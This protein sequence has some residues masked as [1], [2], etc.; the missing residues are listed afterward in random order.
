MPISC[1]PETFYSAQLH[2]FDTFPVTWPQGPA[3]CPALESSSVCTMH[4]SS[5]QNVC[6]HHVPESA[7]IGRLA[8]SKSTFFP[9]KQH[10]PRHC[11]SMTSCPNPRLSWLL[12]LALHLLVPLTKGPRT[13]CGF[14]A[15]AVDTESIT[16]FVLP[17][18]PTPRLSCQ[19]KIAPLASTSLGCHALWSHNTRGVCHASHIKGSLPQ[20]CVPRQNFFT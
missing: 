8:P 2:P 1:F 14:P 15:P 6:S 18:P 12:C 9:I 4:P 5:A 13:Q 11:S 16:S 19:I 20:L 3:C 7:I 17:T 10:R